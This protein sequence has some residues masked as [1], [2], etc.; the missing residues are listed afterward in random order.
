[1]ASDSQMS[2]GETK[3]LDEKKIFRLNFIDS[4]YGAIAVSGDITAATYFR[5]ILDAKTEY[6]VMKGG[7]KQLQELVTESMAEVRAKLLDYVDDGTTSEVQ[8]DKHLERHR[9][10]AIVAYYD[11]KH[12]YLYTFDSLNGIARKAERG[13]VAIGSGSPTARLI[14]SGGKFREIEISLALGLSLYTVEACKKFDRSCGGDV[15]H[16]LLDKGMDGGATTLGK[17]VIRAYSEAARSIDPKIQRFISRE[18]VDEASKLLEE[19]NQAWIAR[20]RVTAAPGPRLRKSA[21][22]KTKP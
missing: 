22:R 13:F 15:Q 1:M 16:L 2:N 12:P 21:N 7:G 18:I 4:F 9:Y 14:L 20:Q 11:N 3:A 10:R 8:R 17:D 19:Y 6:A 5:E